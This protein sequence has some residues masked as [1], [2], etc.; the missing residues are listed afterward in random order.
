MMTGL[1][2]AFLPYSSSTLELHDGCIIHSLDPII[3][4][5]HLCNHIILVRHVRKV[6]VADSGTRDPE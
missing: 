6:M 4:P 2:S 3:R 1:A 5:N